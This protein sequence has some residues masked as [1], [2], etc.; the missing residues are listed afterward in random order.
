MR[1]RNGKA[2]V[3]LV[4]A[5]NPSSNSVAQV[6]PDDVPYATET[7]ELR[8]EPE[9]LE[10]PTRRH[11]GARY[12]LQIL[13]QTDGLAEGQIGAFLR[14]EGLYWSI[15]STWRRQREEGTLASL[16]PRN[17][18]RRASPAASPEAR[19]VRD[20]EKENARLREQL[21]KAR[22]VLDVQKKVLSLCGLAAADEKTS[23]RS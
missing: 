7:P 9:V 1:K 10:R 20:L 2:V 22:L 5:A 19:R 13:E 8:P 15:L 23:S 21:D 17:K 11:Y 4:T 6:L 3:S 18:G 14:R 12:K 16:E